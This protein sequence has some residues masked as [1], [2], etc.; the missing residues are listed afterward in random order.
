MSNEKQ[1]NGETSTSVGNIVNSRAVAV[2]PNATAV[3]TIYEWQDAREL[4][5]LAEAQAILN[6][7]PTE[8][9][10]PL[11]PLSAWSKLPF[12][13]NDHFVGREKELREL[14][15]GLKGG[16][17]VAVGQT[18]ATTGYGGIGKSQLASAFVHRYGGYFAGGVFW[19][20]CGE[21]AAIPSQ[22]AG[23]GGQGHLALRPDF[24]QL[25]LD[26]QVRL[27][28][29]AWSEPIPRL[30]V[31]D[32]CE[33]EALLKGWRPKTGGCRTLVTSRRGEWSAG[34]G[35]Q[36]LPLDVLE[37]ADSVALLRELAGRLTDDEADGIAAELGDFPLALH[38]A[39]SYLNSYPTVSAA[40]YVNQLEEQALAHDSLQGRGATH[41]PTDHELHV[42]RTFA[43]SYERLQADDPI[44]QMGRALLLRAAYFAPNEPIA[45]RWLIIAIVVMQERTNALP[46]GE[47]VEEEAVEALAMGATDGLRRLTGLGLL[48]GDEDEGWRL[49]RLVG[50]YAQSQVADEGA[51]TDVEA[52]INA[53]GNRLNKAG[54]P[55]RWGAMQSHLSHAV[56]RAKERADR[57]SGALCN[58]LG[59]LW[60]AQGRYEQALPYY[61]RALAITEQA[62]GAD[63][64]HTAASLNNLASLWHAQG[65]YEEALPYYERALAIREQALGADHPHTAASLNNLASLWHDQG[66][67]EEAT[68]YYERALAIT[69]QA[70]GADHPHTKV[71]RAHLASLR[72]AMDEEE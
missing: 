51:L 62:L 12:G 32:N 7:L 21:A 33:E 67:Y 14:A 72:Q 65:R 58:N 48:L 57:L 38:L 40:R 8:A 52:V 19:I 3:V 35:V 50:A 63:H 24:E 41:S 13:A 28:K 43:L 20:N 55:L 69:E 37:R 6:Q 25:D 27:V 36:R 42:G 18:M 39:G 49:H 64:P 59:F 34:L 71:V 70:L 46:T 54:Y 5:S 61:E 30:L 26:T 9:I 44:D 15:A 68:P 31:L 56:E 16:E 1:T 47:D 10:P 4:P 60:H 22:V 11:S 53:E 23:C 29:R 2:G 45:S 66:R 17:T